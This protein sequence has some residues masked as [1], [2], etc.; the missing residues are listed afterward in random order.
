MDRAYG[1]VRTTPSYWKSRDYYAGQLRRYLSF[2]LANGDSV[3]GLRRRHLQVRLHQPIGSTDYSKFSSKTNSFYGN[4][5]VTS[6]SA[7]ADARD[8]MSSIPK[9]VDALAKVVEPKSSSSHA[10]TL[11]DLIDTYNLT[12]YDV[13]PIACARPRQHRLPRDRPA[14]PAQG[15]RLQ[16]Q[17]ACGK[18]DSGT[19]SAVK[20]FQK[21]KG[22][23][24]DGQSRQEHPARTVLQ[25]ELRTS[26]TP[27]QGSQRTARRTRLLHHECGSGFG[28]ATPRPRQP[29]VTAGRSTSGSVDDNTSGRAVHGR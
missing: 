1:V 25:A 22:P 14:V 20:K 2:T 21:A 6:D 24:V 28:S 3:H 4:A 13:V 19:V 27:D 12:D 9:F 26:G 5:A 10:K 7:Y 16:H 11:D 23:S 8:V 17:H 15:R 29:P 18:Y